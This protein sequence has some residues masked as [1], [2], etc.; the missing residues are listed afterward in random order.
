MRKLTKEQKDA[1]IERAKKEGR[2]RMSFL[3][4]CPNNSDNPFN[5]GCYIVIRLSDGSYKVIE[6]LYEW[7]EW[8]ELYYARI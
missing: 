8:N 3:F 5:N 7:C 4:E 6:D 2:K 1:M